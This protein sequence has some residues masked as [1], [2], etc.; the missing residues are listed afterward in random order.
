MNGKAMPA[1]TAVPAGISYLSVKRGL[2]KSGFC[3]S[4]KHRPSKKHRSLIPHAL[5]QPSSR[6]PGTGFVAPP[7]G[8]LP[9]L[10]F[11]LWG[12]G[13]LGTAVP[14]PLPGALP[15][16]PPGTSPWTPLRFAPVS[17]GFYFILSAISA[18]FSRMGRCCGQAFSHLP[19]RWHAEARSFSSMPFQLPCRL[20]S[21]LYIAN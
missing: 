9:V 4:G 8:R 17:S 5:A 3:F 18:S 10:A 7:P 20:R 14:K 12:R 6:L 2:M 21:L 15:Q 11:S 1:G 13:M 19:H 16:T